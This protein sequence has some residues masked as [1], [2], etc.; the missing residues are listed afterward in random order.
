MNRSQRRLYNKQ[1]KTRLTKTEFDIIEALNK[2]RTGEF[3]DADYD[4]MKDYLTF[5]NPDLF[6][7]G[8][9]V[10]LNYEAITSR[11]REKFSEDYLAWVEEHK[12]Q[13]LHLLR[14]EG[15]NSFVC[16]RED[17]RMGELD[18]TPTQKPRWMF[19]L[20]TDLLVKTTTGDYVLPRVLDDAN[21]EQIIIESTPEDVANMEKLYPKELEPP[22][23]ATPNE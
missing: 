20:F 18:G 6:P 16:L 19:S 21:R 4:K 1:H 12:G 9:V 15:A 22:K 14:E 3:T 10:K 2:L 5:D 17:N 8:T 23:E 11:D 7:D 13:D